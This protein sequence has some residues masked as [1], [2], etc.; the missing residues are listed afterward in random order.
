MAAVNCHSLGNCTGCTSEDTS[1]TVVDMLFCENGPPENAI[2]DGMEGRECR[3]LWFA[4][5]FSRDT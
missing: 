4:S 1:T 3:I 5:C 2:L